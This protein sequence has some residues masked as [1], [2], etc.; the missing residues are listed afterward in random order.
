MHLLLLL[1][2][3]L[4]AVRSGDGVVVPV[5]SVGK[6]L[7]RSQKRSTRVTTLSS[8]LGC[9]G[10]GGR[11]SGGGSGGDRRRGGGRHRFGVD[12]SGD[13]DLRGGGR[14]R[15]R[16]LVNMFKSG[17]VELYVFF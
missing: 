2:M 15:L 17:L 3:T 8:L 5:Q 16:M 9:D 12:H 1:L 7:I 10:C 14:R 4:L 13:D 6:T 11:H